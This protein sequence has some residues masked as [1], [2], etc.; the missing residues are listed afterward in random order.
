MKAT[1]DT[2]I[3]IHLYD[4]GLEEAIFS[5]FEEV[6]VYDFIIDTELKKH[7][8]EETITKVNKDINDRRIIKISKKDMLCIGMWNTFNRHV[9]ENKRIY[10]PGDLGEVYAIALA[11][12]YGL[13]ILATDDTKQYGPHYMLINELD[14]DVIPLAFYELFIFMFL[15]GSLTAHQVIEYFNKVNSSFEYP[16]ALDRCVNKFYNRFWYD[17]INERENVWF[18]GWCASNNVDCENMFDELWDEIEK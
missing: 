10:N 18:E 11:K 1:L 13:T 8:S 17:P 9:D 16:Q 6:Y 7:G 5:S 14:S 3:I 15:D 2:N 12:T 4:V